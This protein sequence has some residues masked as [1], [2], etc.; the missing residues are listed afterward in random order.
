MKKR[1]SALLLSSLLMA[2][3]FVQMAYAQENTIEKVIVDPSEI[4][5]IAENENL[6]IPEGYHIEEIKY[7]NAYSP[8]ID[9]K[10]EQKIEDDA[11]PQPAWFDSWEVK[12]VKKEDGDYYFPKSPLVSD[13]VYGPAD[14]NQTYSQSGSASFSCNVGVKAEVVEAGVG[15]DVTASEEFSREYQIS[16]SKNQKVNI[17]VYGMYS[18]YTLSVYKNG[19]YQGSG[20]AYKPIGL[21]FEQIAYRR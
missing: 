18:K 17:K 16:V 5:Q 8:T 3:S 7:I 10:I 11:Q 1:F 13:W 9:D 20:A 2:F 15:F 6:E 21:K 19:K 4:Q 12:N 14:Y